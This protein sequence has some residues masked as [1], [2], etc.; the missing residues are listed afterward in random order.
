M[1][2][3]QLVPRRELHVVGSTWNRESRALQE[4]FEAQRPSGPDSN[5]G[6]VVW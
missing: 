5:R 6:S 1:N 3:L 2:K 4:M